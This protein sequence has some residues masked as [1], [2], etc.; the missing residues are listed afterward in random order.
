MRKLNF[1]KYLVKY[2]RYFF[3]ARTYFAEARN[4]FM[5]FFF[6]FFNIPTNP[7]Q[8]TLFSSEHLTEAILGYSRPLAMRQCFLHLKTW[9]N[10][11]LSPEESGLGR[12][13]CF[14][15]HK[16]NYVSFSNKELEQRKGCFYRLSDIQIFTWELHGSIC[17]R[18]VETCLTVL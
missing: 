2:L 18:T 15:A 16:I 10:K 3:T 14:H 6:F 17:Y 9:R 1:K 8:S 11:K 5:S 4:S 7:S 13:M 12:L